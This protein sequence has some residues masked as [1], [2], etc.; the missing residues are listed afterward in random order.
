M[1]EMWVPREDRLLHCGEKGPR[2]AAP[3]PGHLPQE[4][5]GA[6]GAPPGCEG[7][8]WGVLL[9]AG[10]AW[11]SSCV[12]VH[13][14]PAPGAVLLGPEGCPIDS[15]ITRLWAPARMGPEWPASSS[16]PCSR[17]L[18]GGRKHRCQA[19]LASRA[20][21]LPAGQVPWARGCRVCGG[22]GSQASALLDRSPQHPL[23]CL[24][25]EWN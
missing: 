20:V 22:A 10:A 18:W 14:V 9:L 23:D 17:H 1:W 5:P 25:K 2:G 3:A 4:G 8:G 24:E 19:L 13:A 6:A 12:S 16:E 21:H 11:P 7:P 15:P